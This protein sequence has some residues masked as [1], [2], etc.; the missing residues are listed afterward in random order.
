[1]TEFLSNMEEIAL[2]ADEQSRNAEVRSVAVKKRK[3]VQR[4]GEKVRQ[5]A[6]VGLVTH[7]NEQ[8]EPRR[9]EGRLQLPQARILPTRKMKLL[10]CQGILRNG[11]S[12]RR[13]RG[14][15][16]ASLGQFS[17]TQCVRF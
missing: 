17:C 3:Q 5:D 2:L 14:R 11:L 8:G 4:E 10:S 9:K 1:M 7:G 6:T 15:R 16:T 12:G 13:R